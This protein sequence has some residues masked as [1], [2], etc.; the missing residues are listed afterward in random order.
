MPP[1]PVEEQ[2]RQRCGDLER[3]H[4]GA[5]P[6]GQ[7]VADRDH[8]HESQVGQPVRPP[9]VAPATARVRALR[10]LLGRFHRRPLACP[11][12]GSAAMPSRP[13]RGRATRC[14]RRRQRFSLSAAPRAT[15]SSQNQARSNGANGRPQMQSRPSAVDWRRAVG[16]SSS[17]GGWRL[18]AAAGSQARPV[19]NPNVSRDREP[20]CNIRSGGSEMG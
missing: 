11:S 20:V 6:I 10:F 12:V 9:A 16:C 3:E 5:Q 14:H 13:C 4:I 8:Q 17:A 2:E 15:G 7:L 18:A 19:P 1:V